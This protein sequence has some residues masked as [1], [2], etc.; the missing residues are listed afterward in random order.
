MK[1]LKLICVIYL[2]ALLSD[3]K[4]PVKESFSHTAKF[5][6]TNLKIKEERGV[7]KVRGQVLYLPIYSN[8]P[9]HIDSALIDISAIIAVH[10]T[11]LQHN[12]K[13]TNVLYFNT[14]GMLVKD[15]LKHNDITLNPL[16][17]KTFYIPHEDKSGTGANFIVEWTSEKPVIEPLIESVMLN[18]KGNQN[19]SFSSL[20]RVIRERN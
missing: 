14:D 15:F 3:C 11:D 5:D 13:I 2:V 18:A 20:G 17:T 9:S 6:T 4:N 10:N 12:I 8:L 7:K 16:V 1:S 19:I